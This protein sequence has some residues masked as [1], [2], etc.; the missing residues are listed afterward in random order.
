MGF[1]SAYTGDELVPIPH[2]ERDDYWVKLKRYVPYGATEKSEVALQEMEMVAGR[3]QPAPNLRKS[4][5]ELLLASI[6]GWNL[7]DDNEYVWPINMQSIRRL[8]KGVA[9]L[10]HEKV[11]ELGKPR[12]KPEQAQFPAEVAGGDQESADRGSADPVAVPGGEGV[13]AAAGPEA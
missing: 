11:E 7:D 13:V 6:V 12:S 1:L 10:L 3:P 2:P 9:A 4:K 5:D 8:P